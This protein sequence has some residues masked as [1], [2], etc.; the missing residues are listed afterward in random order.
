M[1]S[2]S[3]LVGSI[4]NYNLEKFTDEEVYELKIIIMC[5]LIDCIDSINKYKVIYSNIDDFYKEYYKKENFKNYII[6]DKK[7]ITSIFKN[8]VDKQNVLEK[9]ISHISQHKNFDSDYNLLTDI[10]KFVLGLLEQI[11]SNTDLLITNSNIQ[12]NYY[13]PNEYKEF[14]EEFME[15]E[16]EYPINLVRLW[17]WTK[18]IEILNMFFNLDDD[19]GHIFNISN[20]LTELHFPLDNRGDNNTEPDILEIKN[21]I[22][23]DIIKKTKSKPKNNKSDNQFDNILVNFGK[24]KRSDSDIS[25]QSDSGSKSQTVELFGNINPNSI[26]TIKIEEFIEEV[27]RYSNPI[28]D[29]GIKLPNIDI[30]EPNSSVGLTNNLSVNILNNLA[31]N[32]NS[33]INSA[34]L[35]ILQFL[36]GLNK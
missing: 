27:P 20:I 36:L 4:Q 23:Q 29:S 17:T 15:R 32:N 6:T 7:I 31:Q 2:I 26:I 18:Y 1:P 35:Q 34:N 9:L 19:Y 22:I 24:R 30:E 3:E 10:C 33:N 5:L 8:D 13:G 25:N 11:K 28:N 16:S 12:I 21:I 14:V